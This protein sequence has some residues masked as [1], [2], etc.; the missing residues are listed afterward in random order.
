[1]RIWGYLNPRNG[2]EADQYLVTHC[3]VC[4]TVAGVWHKLV[5]SSIYWK[6]D[7]KVLGS[8]FWYTSLHVCFYASTVLFWSLQLCNMALSQVVWCTSLVLF[9][10]GCFGS[11]VVL[12]WFPVHFR[13]FFL[14]LWEK[15]PLVFWLGLHLMCRFLSWGGYFHNIHP[16]Q[17]HGISFQLFVSSLTSFI[18]I[19]PCL[20]PRSFT[21]LVKFVPKYFIDYDA[22]VNGIS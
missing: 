7:V 16:T 12:L 9:S 20:L 17:K 10:L 1:M 22:I 5:V 14:F 21:S 6:T 4:S 18:N 2:S 19:L 8:L 11:S 15:M 3:W 13:I